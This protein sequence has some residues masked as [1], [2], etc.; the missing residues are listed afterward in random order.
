MNAIE[1]NKF[2][3]KWLEFMFI[4]IFF[5]SLSQSITSI[6]FIVMQH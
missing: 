5:Y 6:L 2:Q 1:F 3:K 4:S